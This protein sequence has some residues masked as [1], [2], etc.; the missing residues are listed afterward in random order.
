MAVK[1]GGERGEGS[2]DGWM[3]GWTGASHEGNLSCN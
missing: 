1:K 3:D 2:G